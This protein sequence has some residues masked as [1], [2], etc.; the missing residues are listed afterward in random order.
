[1]YY[2]VCT[3]KHHSSVAVLS[4]VPAAL[5]TIRQQTRDISMYTLYNIACLSYPYIESTDSMITENHV[6]TGFS[7]SESHFIVIK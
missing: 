3:G 1:M 2:T 6:A 5:V 7:L 4:L